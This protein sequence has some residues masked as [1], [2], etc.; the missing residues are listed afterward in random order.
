MNKNTVTQPLPL[1]EFL[2]RPAQINAELANQLVVYR[3]P[4]PRGESVKSYQ[5]HIEQ[6]LAGYRSA[7]LLRTQ[8]APK[9]LFIA[10]HSEAE[11]PPQVFSADKN[12]VLPERVYYADEFAPIWIRLI[13]RRMSAW[14]RLCRGYHKA[15]YPL[16]VIDSWQSKTLK[17]IETLRLDCSSFDADTEGVA[18]IE[19]FYEST[20]R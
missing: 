11:I 4:L 12:E 17:G 2:Y 10:V 6:Q 3:Y 18:R 7:F 8:A 1:F 20:L 5:L 14:D 15:G 13:F 9:G 16:L 19:P